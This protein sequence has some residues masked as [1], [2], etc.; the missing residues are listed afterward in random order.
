MGTIPLECYTSK[1][2]N[3]TTNKKGAVTGWTG[4]QNCCL[5]KSFIWTQGED[6]SAYKDIKASGNIEFQ[7]GFKI[8]DDADC[9]GDALYSGD[10]TENVSYAM[11]DWQELES[12][13][14]SLFTAATAFIATSLMF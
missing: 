6:N 2:T 10:S 4:Q 8:C 7:T 14:S 12:G 5:M 13:A 11:H 3:K 9:S 1:T